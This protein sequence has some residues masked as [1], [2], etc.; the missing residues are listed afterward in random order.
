MKKTCISLLLM[1]GLAF[2]S[3]FAADYGLPSGIQ[4]GNI[5]HCFNW[6]ISEVK[7]N[8]QNIAN[9]GFGTVQLSPLQRDNGS[10]WHDLYRPYD[11]ALG[12][13]LGTE[14]ELKALC[15]EAKTYGIKVIVDV[16]ANH[17]DKTS[18]YHDTWWDSNSRV[19]WN[20]SIDYSNRYSITHGQLGDYGDINS[21]QSDVQARAKA[22]VQKLKDC[23]VSGCRWDAA[24]HIGLPSEGCNFWS[25]VTSVSDM[26]HYGEILDSPG[27]SANIISEYANYMSV[28]DNRYSNSAARDNGGLPTG[29]GGDWAVNYDLGSKCVYWGESH[30][31]YS[32]DEWSQN[33]DQSVIDRAYAAMACRNDAA[34]L[35]LARPSAK[36]F[37]NIKIGKGT[38]AYKSTAISAVNKFRNKMVGRADYFTNN[39]SAV[40]VTRKNGGAVIVSKSS[41]SV[42][43]ANGGGYCPA[44][45]YKDRVSGNTFTVTATTISGTV[46]STGIAVIYSDDISSSG[47]DSGDSG[48]SSSSSSSSSVTITGDYNLAYS[49]S[50]TYVHYW[51]G[52]ASSSWP[53]VAF[54]TVT[55]SDGNT[56]KVAKVADGT[57]G[58]V[59]SDNG[60]NQTGDLT[61][62]SAYVMNDSGNTSTAVTFSNGSSG[63]SDSSDS[64]DNNSGDSGSDNSGTTTTGDVKCYFNN[65]GNWSDV[66]VW[67]WD[68]DNNDAQKTSA[69]AWPGEKITST[70]SNGYYIW[71]GSKGSPTKIIFN[72]GSGT[73]TSNL[74][75][76]NGKVY[77]ASGNISDYPSTS[78]GSSD[79]TPS[80]P[81]SVTITGDY[82]LA[83]SGS[84][85]YVHYWGGTASSSWPG[86][87]FETAT[88]SDGNTYKVAKVAD[89]TTGLVFSDKGSNQTGDLT[90]SSAYVMDDS[91][92]TTT[93]V[94][95][96]N[97]S[98]G[99]NSGTDSSTTT[100]EVK[101]YFNNTGNWTNVYVWAWDADNNDAQM[102][103][104]SAWPGEQITSKDSNGYYIWT[105][106][107]GSPTKIIFNNG[108]GT[109]TSDLEYQN[110][111]VY[112]ASGNISDYNSSSSGNDSSDDSDDNSGDNTGDDSGTTGITDG[113]F[114]GDRTDFR[115]ET[116]YF[117]MTTRFY[118][119]DPKNNVLTWDRQ[120]QQTSTKD[121]AWRGDFAGL[122]DK[123]DYIKALGFTAIWITPV[124]QNGS[125][126]D[127][128]GYHAMDFSSVD[129]RLQSKTSQGSS[130]DVDFQDLIDAAHAKGLKIIL[131][132]VLQH[133]GN[134]G[135]AKLQKLFTRNQNIRNQARIETSMIPDQE[136]LGGQ[137]YWDLASAKQYTNRFQ[138]LKTEKDTHNYWHHLANSWNWDE[139]SRWWGQ[140]AGDC[141][142][143]NTE[144]PGVTDY[145]VDCY[146]K[147]IE[148]GVDGFRIDTSGHISRLTFNT[149]FIPQ[150]TALGE[151]YKSKRLNEAPFYMFGE[152]CARYGGVIYRDNHAL[153]S[154]FYT[155]K[156]PTSLT[157]Q[158]NT[159]ASWWDQQTIPEGSDTR[160]GN[161]ALCEQDINFSETSTNAFMQNGAYHTPDYS[162]SSGY[163]VIDFPMHYNF[164]SAGSAVN[165]AK[166]GDQY[167][168]D[169]TWN[170]VYV[171]S[172]D[173][174]PQPN[175]GVR[176]SGGTLQWAENL[177]LMFTFRG[178]PCI[179]YGSEVEFQAGKVIDDGMNTALA[180]TGRAYYGAYLEGD[181]SASDFG[182]YTASG[183]VS[184][185]LNGDL[186]HHIR[187]LNK[188]RA[189]VPAL[190][191]GQYTFDGCSA[192]GGW[193]FKRAWK[194][195]YA[196]VAINGGAT[197]TNVPAGT[198][199]D[200]VTGQTYQGGGTITVTAPTNQGQ[201]RVLVKGWTGGKVVEDGK[202]IY[203]TSSVSKGG[204]VTATDPGAT[205]W[206]GS[207]D[208]VGAP[209]VALSPNGGSFKTETLTVTASLNDAAVSGKI[210]VNGSTFS[211]TSGQTK[212]FT[213]GSGM[214]YGSSATVSWTATDSDG[215]S[216]TGSATY[217][218]VDPSAVITVYVKADTAPYLYVWDDDK[219]TLNGTWPGK[220]LTNTKTA[221]GTEFWYFPVENCSKF[222][223]IFNNGS[224]SQTADITGITEDTYFSY[225]GSTGYS[226]LSASSYADVATVSVSPDGGTYD[227]AVEVTITPENSTTA[228]YQV[229][230]GETV[231]ISSPTTITI[232]SDEVP[233]EV[234]TLSWGASSSSAKT[235]GARTARVTTNTGSVVFSKES[236]TNSISDMIA[237]ARTYCYFDN[238]ANWD[239]VYV[240]AWNSNDNNKQMT[241]AS[242][243]P[244]EELTTR[245][246]SGYY[247]W[248]GSIGT[249]THVVFSNGDG[250]K[251]KDLTFTKGRVYDNYGN[252]SDYDTSLSTSSYKIYFDNSNSNWS[253]VK[254]HYWGGES[255][256]TW[257]GDDMT[258]LSGSLYVYEVPAG[259]T[260][261]VFNNGSG[262]KT[263]DFTSIIGQTYMAEADSSVWTGIG[264]V[265]GEMQ[266]DSPVFYNLQGFRVANP[267]AGTYIMV[268]GGKA[269]KVIMK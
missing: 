258:L 261:L 67:A 73:Q 156:S 228:W 65:S 51:G 36:G 167:Y 26:Y 37:S 231:T 93:A 174:C 193:A 9:A 78:S 114:V 43:I 44:G 252:I 186:A 121:P 148:M 185:T 14:A 250:T 106:S 45:S 157:S 84:H 7:A 112:D 217:K 214:S 154:H 128:H 100:T 15:A 181:V 240:W 19:R 137:S 135:E 223:V 264:Q 141:V 63:G 153:S 143:L 72:N 125:G 110:G 99:G 35:Y 206:Y 117:A 97:G 95:F 176:F 189:A 155:W 142:D 200:I 34:A 138:Y 127:Y 47:T 25:T 41:G 163:N 71:T 77:D 164:N 244:G 152:V 60:S 86:V 229:G 221:N 22:Y 68:A 220:Q 136:K 219:N 129:L 96:S 166:E 149:S 83:Y 202:F 104:A 32:N 208:A 21:E 101:C 266:S 109:K 160:W 88:G 131:D 119:G 107:K 82:N 232:G 94:T 245:D 134:F 191:K 87:A 116:I 215:N 10:A 124:V 122:I 12:T 267:S 178:I 224:G 204:S 89:G 239:K 198:Y 190:R 40:S 62:S 103:S 61:Y 175:D 132:I 49:G 46:G 161:M 4:Q 115:D 249:P 169:A 199:T 70:D 8:L 265:C 33:V 209:A 165:I 194:D 56:Y 262:T 5:L 91:G 251:T 92:N 111:K 133:T 74:E 23:G 53:G 260:G 2:T 54:E 182:V 118:D 42:S 66:Y 147:F 3:M 123:L 18:G 254:V 6:K 216:Q 246:A 172:H 188:I 230:N 75:Y 159:D 76:Q 168:N 69:S 179:Y 196:L 1:T 162:K 139:I 203:T 24:K 146:G 192:S 269:T 130:R 50:H 120:D 248:T 59:F 242:A 81:A 144:N 151:K 257:P 211:L 39:G 255:T 183:Q 259:T 158:W 113:T 30:D 213:I 253:S 195:S 31:T 237:K 58:L 180:N 64:S 102:T 52:T 256:S 238:S 98:S 13:V 201:L 233:G 55:G 243:W 236:Q 212:T 90:Y 263:S 79:P 140:I 227:S 17:V 80:T 207:D 171:D 105:G 187:M 184:K 150:F 27:P 173:Y 108:S 29:Y 235:S 247:L 28:T 197:F 170:V 218:K 48:S 241:S 20:G 177:S 226:K 210:T 268:R 222:N 38:D 57:T 205:F 16:V 145:L 225:N 234:T 85:T 11:L 126:I